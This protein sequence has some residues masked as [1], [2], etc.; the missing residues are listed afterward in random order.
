MN[1]MGLHV[2]NNYMYLRA[3]LVAQM[4]KNP[5]AV[6]ETL[7]WQR[8]RLQCGRPGFDP[9]VGRSPGEGKGN[10]L[11]CPC[12]ENFMDCIVHGVAKSQTRQRDFHFHFLYVFRQLR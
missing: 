2:F 1:Y 6:W 5:P 4:A 3:S 12:L 9:W 7:R 8:I 10:S 11:Q